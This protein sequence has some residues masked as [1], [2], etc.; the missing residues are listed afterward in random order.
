VDA[1]VAFV[2]GVDTAA[3]GD[4]SFVAFVPVANLPSVAPIDAEARCAKGD[5]EPAGSTARIQ[6][7]TAKVFPV[8]V[9]F[10]RVEVDGRPVFSDETVVPGTRWAQGGLALPA[11]RERRQRIAN[12][13]EPPT[14]ERSTSGLGRE[15]GTSPHLGP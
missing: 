13:T 6:N 3:Q 9:D 4:V 11:A 12:G 7:R 8:E 5:E 1:A 2:D 14:G 15:H 10:R